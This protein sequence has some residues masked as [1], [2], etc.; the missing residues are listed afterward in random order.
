M[1][2][3]EPRSPGPPHRVHRSTGRHPRGGGPAAA[4]TFEPL[5]PAKGSRAPFAES[6]W[7]RAWIAALEESSLDTGR[8][9]RGRTYA[10]GG[11]VGRV[12][13]APGSAT[14]AVQGSRPDPYRSTM[15]VRQLTGEEWDRL[16]DVIAERAANIAALLDG[17]MPPGLA[18]DA[19]AAEV[20]LLPGPQDLQPRCNCPDWG[21]PCKH[22][23]ALCYQVGR[24]LDRDPF[25]LLLLRG[26]G[27]EELTDELGRRNL[28]RAAA[29][30]VAPGGGGDG[31]GDDGGAAVPRPPDADPAGAVFSSRSELPP[32]PPVPPLP[33][34]IGPGPRLTE[35][36][37]PAP[38]VDPVGLELL[39]AD[40][41]IR[42]HRL[43]ASALDSPGHAGS[44][45][46]ALLTEW[47]DTARLAATHPD[48]PQASA[49]LSANGGHD[50]ARL[51]AA[52]SAWRH[53]GAAGLDVL[54][55]SWNP[56]PGLLARAR[57]AL[58]A[59]WSD[60]PPPRL[61]TWRNRWTV[62]DGDVQLRLGTD[63]LWYPYR[64][65]RGAWQPA[66]R[67]DTDP[68]LVLAALLGR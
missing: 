48:G 57:D 40:G 17:E 56:P 3:A 37:P 10:R 11:A 16:L 1:S 33:D 30:A 31:G 13:V 59:G 45:L 20:P 44:P 67:G 58:L 32:L 15:R 63:G 2:P 12:T 43:L 18:D 42:A 19:R 4:R 41:A 61:R 50:P 60:G 38:G 49:R 23:A 39:V 36:S 6:W 64:K 26:R 29:E 47:Q 53:G 54:D 9:Q 52:A 25:V 24:L 21:F 35:T 7:G 65:D 27:E 14:A 5:P 28:A 62:V 46:P 8:L 34:R 68:S 66:G 22:A 55:G 51:A